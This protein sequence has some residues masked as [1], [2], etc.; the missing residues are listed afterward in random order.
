MIMFC[1]LN[2]GLCVLV[3]LSLNRKMVWL[4]LSFIVFLLLLM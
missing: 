1:I 3:V 2:V 4:L